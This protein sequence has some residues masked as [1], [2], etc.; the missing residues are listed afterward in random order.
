MPLTGGCPRLA[1]LKS[2]SAALAFSGPAILESCGGVDAGTGGVR[3]SASGF[4]IFSHMHA[5]CEIV[6]QASRS[7]ARASTSSDSTVC[8]RPRKFSTSE[9]DQ[10]GPPAAWPWRPCRAFSTRPRRPRSSAS[11]SPML[12]MIG[13]A[14]S[15][16]GLNLRSMEDAS[17]VPASSGPPRHLGVNGGATGVTSAAWPSNTSFFCKD[18]TDWEGSIIPE[19]SWRTKDC[20]LRHSSS[21]WSPIVSASASASVP[22]GP[23]SNWLLATWQSSLPV[24]SGPELRWPSATDLKLATLGSAV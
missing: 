3:L 2:W 14:T 20:A 23:P 21:T 8:K 16:A 17:P 4:S 13:S 19:P 24:L 18:R 22:L 7:S 11:S 10:P 9:L 15:G 5:M 6:A 1:S 12:G